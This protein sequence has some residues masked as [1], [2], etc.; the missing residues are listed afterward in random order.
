MPKFIDHHSKLPPA[1]AMSAMKASLGKP[2]PG[3]ITPVGGYVT[4]DG[5]GFC[6]IDAPSKAAVCAVHAS[7]GVSL[8]ERDVHEIS[9]SL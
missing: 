4:A 7:M 6:V 5:H 2:L 1:E 9:A 3:G 8:D